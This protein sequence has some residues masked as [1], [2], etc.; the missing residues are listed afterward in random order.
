[1]TQTRRRIGPIGT[2]TRLLAGAGL[3]YLA[4]F[5][6]TSWGLEWYDAAV[7]LGVCRRP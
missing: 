7:G 1:M 4:F 6:G 3:L 5:D 2:S